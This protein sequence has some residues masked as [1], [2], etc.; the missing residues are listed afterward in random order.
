VPA[1]STDPDETDFRA[2][3]G[4]IQDREFGTQPPF[5]CTTPGPSQV[6]SWPVFHAA[7]DAL[8]KWV[9]FGLP[10]REAPPL[11]VVDPGPPANISRDADGIA[12][13]GIRL[14][15]V[16]VPNSLN[17]GINSPANLDNPLNAFCVLYGTHQ[18]FTQAQLDA[19]YY[20]DRDY[21][22]LVDDDVRLLEDQHFLLPEDGS[23]FVDQARHTHVVG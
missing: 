22:Q 16:A 1:Y 6:T 2:T 23:F 3:L 15:D 19:L 14:P 10:P 18:A 4:G 12:Q 17:N 13:G 20:S 21:R 9:R 11:A 8:D 7:Y 5:D